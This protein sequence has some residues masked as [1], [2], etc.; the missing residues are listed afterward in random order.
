M[1]IYKKFSQEVYDQYDSSTCDVVMR[2]LAQQGYYCRRT[3]DQYG[4]DIEVYSG[5]RLAW[6]VEV[7]RK[8]VWKS[9]GFP[10]LTVQIP[11]RK[12]KLLKYSRKPLEFYVVSADLSQALVIN[13]DSLDSSS[14]VEV[15]NSRISGGELFFQIPVEQATLVKLGED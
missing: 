11:E 1:G 3:P 6:H 5:Y 7:E 10:W 15:P 14:L 9:G 8:L 4:P 12:Q 13:G 2:Y